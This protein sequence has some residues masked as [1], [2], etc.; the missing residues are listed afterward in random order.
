MVSKDVTNEMR[1]LTERDDLVAAVSHELRTPLTAIIGY[2][3]LAAEESDLTPL[4]RREIEVALR[5]ARR[6][7][8][9]IDDLLI[10]GAVERDEITLALTAVDLHALVERCVEGQRPVAERSGVTVVDRTADAGTVTADEHRVTQ[11]VDNLIS[12]AVKYSR[13]GGEVR[14]DAERTESTVRLT[15]ADDGTGIAPADQEH[16]FEQFFRAPAVRRGAVHGT[17]LGLYI[18]RY[19]IEAHGGSIVARSAPEH[20]T[21][22]TVELPADR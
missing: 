7:V 22:M 17:G 15:I 4:L 2:L 20:G 16:L 3:E 13:P 14:I 9:L 11:V 6:L 5:N 10:A 19:L 12:N 18:A 8:P 1:A 21:T